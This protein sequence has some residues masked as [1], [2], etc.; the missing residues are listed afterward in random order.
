MKTRGDKEGF[1]GTDLRRGPDGGARKAGLPG[2][3]H[4]R[5]A[6]R[7][8]RPPPDCGRVA[9]T[10]A[11]VQTHVRAA[12]GPAAGPRRAR[13]SALRPPPGSASPG[14]RSPVGGPGRGRSPWSPSPHPGP[15]SRG[16]WAVGWGGGPQG[17]GALSAAFSGPAPRVVS[18]RD[19]TRPRPPARAAPVST[20]RVVA[21]PPL[22]IPSPRPASVW[23]R[24]LRIARCPRE[25]QGGQRQAGALPRSLGP[26]RG[27][28]KRIAGGGCRQPGRGNP[29]TAPSQRRVL[30]PGPQLSPR[31]SRWAHPRRAGPTVE[32]QI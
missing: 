12:H 21:P 26:G 4:R 19:A 30:A 2:T 6:A 8:L 25:P 13:S 24:G 17:R 14:R 18:P 10:H 9:R 27:G 28:G 11:R 7:R 31:A 1:R 22:P 16:D 15:V 3:S 5:P 32:M 29:H 20:H 23:L